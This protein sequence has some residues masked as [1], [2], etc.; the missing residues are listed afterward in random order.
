VAEPSKARRLNEATW[1][2]APKRVNKIAFNAKIIAYKAK[3][4]AY[5]R[6]N[7]LKKII[8]IQ[9]ITLEHTNRGVT[10][11]WVYENLIK[12]RFFIHKNTFYR[13]LTINAKAEMNSGGKKRQPEDKRQLK[14]FQ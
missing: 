5:N 11:S 4:M 9:E 12:D 2:S 13:Y 10:E 6:K 1:G 14:L 3:I 7:L 8:A